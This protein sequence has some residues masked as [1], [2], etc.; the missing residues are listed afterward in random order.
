MAAAAKNLTPVVL[1]LG[2]KSPV[3][4]DSDINLQV[5]SYSLLLNL[6]TNTDTE[7]DMDTNMSTMIII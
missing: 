1:E 2:G 4:V 3:I 5:Y 6:A 7:Y